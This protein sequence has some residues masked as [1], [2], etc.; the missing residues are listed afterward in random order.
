MTAVTW[1]DQALHTFPCA[2]VMGFPT[3]SVLKFIASKR[4]HSAVIFL[5][6]IMLDHQATRVG[7]V[8]DAEPA[9]IA[10][11][12]CGDVAL[13]VVHIAELMEVS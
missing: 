12:T 3:S 9:A 11:L 5:F 4:H 10:E 1:W 8:K 7:A 6:P 2:D 13:K